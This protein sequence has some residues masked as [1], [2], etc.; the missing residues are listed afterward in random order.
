MSAL[1]HKPTYA[2]Q[3]AM[4]ALPPM[5]TA[6]ADITSE[7]VF[8]KRAGRYRRIRVDTEFTCKTLLLC[9][10]CDRSK[11]T[12]CPLLALSRHQLVQRTCPL[13]RGKR[14]RRFA[15]HMAASDRRAG[16]EG[17]STTFDRSSLR[18]SSANSSALWSK[19]PTHSG[20]SG[21]GAL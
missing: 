6:K 18:N 21:D 2:P 17:S 15:V 13:L 12:E 7:E 8:Y 9:N 19:R 4:S 5:A 20:N 1:G 14:T 10:Q 3:Q 11:Q 16:A